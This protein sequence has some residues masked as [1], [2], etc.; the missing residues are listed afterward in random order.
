MCVLVPTAA[1][2]RL[3]VLVSGLGSNLAALL[4]ACADPSYGAQVVAVG[5]DRKQI[6]GLDRATERN[7]P[8][9]VHRVADFPDRAAWDAAMTKS[10]AAQQPDLVISAGFMKLAGPHFLAAFGGRYLNTHPALLPAFPG[11]HGPAEALAYGVKLTG[12]TLFMVDAGVD[13]GPIIAQC[14]VPVLDSDDVATLHDRI[15]AA[16]RGMLVDVVGRM[17]RDGWTHSSRKVTIP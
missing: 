3:V 7:I 6:G 11:M 15:K 17:A 4:T 10:V 12:A 1:P 9:F 16:E 14:A 8:T 2:R 5:A 13:T